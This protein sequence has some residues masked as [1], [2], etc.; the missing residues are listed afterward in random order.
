M[1]EYVRNVMAKYKCQI[2]GQLIEIENIKTIDKCPICSADKSFLELVTETEEEILKEITGPIPISK[3]NPGIERIDEK[4]IRCGLCSKVCQQQVGIK[5]NPEKSL[6]PVCISCGQCIINCPVGAITPKYCYKRVNDYIQDTEKTVIAF[7]SPAVRVALGEEFSSLEQNVEGKMI[8]ALKELGF[9]YVLDTT[10]GADLTIMEEATELIERIQ[11]KE[12]LPQFTSCC[13]AWVK[14]LEMYHPKLINH[15]STCKSP[16]GMQGTM[17]KTYY[18]EMMNIPKENIIAVAI[19]P[20]TAKKYEIKLPDNQDTDFVIT[21][22]ELAM[23]IR[24][25][26]L[27]FNSLENGDFDPIMGKGTGA[28]VIFGNS[29]GVMEAAVRTA[30]HFLTGNTPPKEL[31]D[32]QPVRGYNKVKE[33]TVTIDSIKLRLLIVHGMMNIEPFLKQLEAG[34]IPY[35]MIEVMNCPGGCIGG[36]GQPLGVVSRQQEIAEKRIQALYQED[37]DLQM[38]NSYENPDIIDIYQSYLNYPKSEKAE[39]LLHTKYENK[40]SIL[41][42]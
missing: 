20:C 27:D 10:F 6:E 11:K 22:S 25:K 2:C 26:E 34:S 32:F 42:E 7:T 35:D 30:Y 4:C 23:M 33:A 41:G 17:I 38:K 1:K 12:N 9:D 13:P 40:S 16:I 5:Y 39:E 28:G 3:E 8:S 29:G 37:T 36:G 19:T 21:T 24:E 31:L 18:S 14:Y 15:L